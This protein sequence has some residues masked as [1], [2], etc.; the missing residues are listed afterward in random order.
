MKKLRDQIESDAAPPRPAPEGRPEP[1][2]R[3]DARAGKRMLAGY[4]SEAMCREV[5][6]LAALNGKTVQAMLGEAI[7]AI[8]PKYG[9]PPFGER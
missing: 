3:R 1:P 2:A 5:A 9:K 6:A 7:D 8:M 4:F